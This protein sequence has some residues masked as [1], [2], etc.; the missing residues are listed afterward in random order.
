MGTTAPTAPAPPAHM[1]WSRVLGLGV[2]AAL[3]LAGGLAAGAIPLLSR[4]QTVRNQAATDAARH[5]RVAVTVATRVAPD[6]VRVLPGNCLPLTEIAIYPRTTGYL[7]RWTVDIGDQVKAGQ[8][9]AE[10]ATPEIDAQLEQARATLIQDRANLVRAE[11]Q[12]V[13]AKAEEKREQTAY[14][15]R[16]Q[17]KDLYDLAV[18]NSQVATATVRALE[19]TLRVDQAN[20]LRLETLQ[21]FQ[22]VTAPFDGVITAR[23]IDPGALVQA[24]TPTTTRELFHLMRTDTVR[25][26]VNVPQTFSTT[27]T[28]GQ[29]VT[30]YRREDPTRTFAGKVARTADALDPNT[31]TLLTEVH[32]P[33]PD[34]ALRPGMYLQVRFT[35]D[36]SIFPVMIPSAAVVIRSQAPTVGVLDGTN[37]VR[38]RAVQLGRDYGAEVEVKV[39]LAPGEQVVVHP[40]DD[41]PEG[42]VVEPVTQPST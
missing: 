19:A 14:D 22:K 34:N 2:L 32:V 23:N 35:F 12:E 18:A 6:A 16:V 39:G 17:S 7:K 37:T 36:R 41:L 40:G 9:L 27:I 38:Y 25:V 42:T 28:P 11:A 8:L 30:V 4:N 20:I 3:L 15:S 21:S 5:P 33:N 29:A 26:W 31:R 10:I 13:Y 24:D 1:R